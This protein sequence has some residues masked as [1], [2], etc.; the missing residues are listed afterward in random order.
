MA[1][2]KDVARVVG[3]SVGTV[4]RILNQGRAHLYSPDTCKRV[5]DAAKEMG[6]RPNRSAQ[7]MRLRKTHIIGFA[8]TNISPDGY[9]QSMQVHPF[10]VGLSRELSQAGYHVA[11]VEVS[12]LGDPD[13]PEQPWSVQDRFLDALVVH[14]GMSDR[15]ARFADNVGVPLIWWDSGVFEAHNCIYR[16]EITVG[17]QVT[18]RLVELGHRRIGYMAGQHGWESYQAGNPAHY[19]YAQRFESY[20]DEMRAHGLSEVPVIGYDPELIAKQ[21]ADNQLTA[22]IMQGSSDFP[23]APALEILKWQAPRDF[24]Y[25]SLDIE[26]RVQRRGRQIGGML[27]D[28]CQLGEEAAKMVLAMLEHERKTVPSVRYTGEFVI[29][30]T[31]STPRQG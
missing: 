24:S 27:Y 25:A 31:I 26:A 17:R 5:L 28:R 15:A 10:S 19:S 16:D 6:Y 14:Y 29:G 2:L 11:L 8:A 12:D 30:N 22:A 3:V 4:S 13:Q 23:I 7:A 1:A 18:R 20:R 21:L 9:L